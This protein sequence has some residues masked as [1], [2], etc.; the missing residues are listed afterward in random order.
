MTTKATVRMTLALGYWVLGDI[1]RHWILQLLGDIFHCD[2]QYD[3][4]QKTELISK[5]L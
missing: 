5:S 3:T 1:H 4:D 2:T